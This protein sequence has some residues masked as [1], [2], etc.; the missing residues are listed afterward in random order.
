MSIGENVGLLNLVSTRDL[1]FC[2][3]LYVKMLVVCQFKMIV[4][5]FAFA[6]LQS[7]GG[8]VG[9]FKSNVNSRLCAQIYG[10]LVRVFLSFAI[11]TLKGES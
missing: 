10:K 2:S 9:L 5:F 4:F 11:V 8:N 1:R 7:I 6:L 3:L